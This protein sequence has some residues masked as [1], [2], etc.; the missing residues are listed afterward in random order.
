MIR[1]SYLLIASLIALLALLATV[2]LQATSGDSP[3][4]LIDE[5]KELVELPPRGP[6]DWIVAQ[7]AYPGEKIPF[8][9]FEQAAD[10]TQALA[11]AARAQAPALAKAKWKAE[12]PHQVGGRVVDIAVDPNELNTVYAAVATGG[13]WKSTDAGLTFK[14][15]WPRGVTL[16]MGALAIASD[17]TLYAGTGEAN[18]GG[19][20]IVYGGTGVYKSTNGGKSWKRTGL[21]RTGAIGR[22]VVDPNNDKKVYVAASGPLFQRGGDRGLYLTTNAG[23]SWKRVLKGANNTTGAVDIAIDPEDSDRVFVSMWDHIRMPDLR[24]YGGIGSGLYRSTNGGKSFKRLGTQQG[25]PQP[26]KSIGRIGVAVG[27]TPG[28]RRTPSTRSTSRP[29]GSS[30]SSTRTSPTAVTLSVLHR[31]MLP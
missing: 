18:P 13:V 7:R 2:A 8:G 10:D 22:I 16:S 6:D 24:V 25:L 11:E 5:P 9:A 3:M 1:R 12:G 19:G 14:P 31:V 29:T 17:G 26:D 23:K 21:A 27:S 28:P 15:A 30:G 20:S 4:R